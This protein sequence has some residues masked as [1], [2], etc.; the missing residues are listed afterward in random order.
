MLDQ[1]QELTV[2]YRTSDL[3]LPSDCLKLPRQTRSC[4]HLEL[5]RK[6]KK[7]NVQCAYQLELMLQCIELSQYYFLISCHLASTP[8]IK[9]AQIKEVHIN[10][11]VLSISILVHLSSNCSAG[12]NLASL[13]IGTQF[14]DNRVLQGWCN[15]KGQ[16]GN[17]HH[18]GSLDIKSQ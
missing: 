15:F 10:W 16:P 12:A 14:W 2:T 1:R 7:H 9:M 4:P 5:L 6:F 18:S 13:F 8:W 17:L 3:S 11:R